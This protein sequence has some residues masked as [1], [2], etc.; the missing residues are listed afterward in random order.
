MLKLT[1][2]IHIF[3]YDYANAYYQVP[4]DN[5]LPLT[6]GVV[7]VTS[8]FVWRR[9]HQQQKSFVADRQSLR[10]PTAAVSADGN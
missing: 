10:A 1:N 7:V 2:V 6:G 5:V 3:A 4:Q 8:L 9:Q